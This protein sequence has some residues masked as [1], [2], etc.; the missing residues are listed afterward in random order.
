[1]RE[2]LE[3][4]VQSHTRECIKRRAQHHESRPLRRIPVAAWRR[5]RCSCGTDTRTSQRRCCSRSRSRGP[6]GP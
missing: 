5:F 1:V 3:S 2:T 6:G 4:P